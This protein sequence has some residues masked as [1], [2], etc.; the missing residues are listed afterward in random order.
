MQRI[1]SGIQATGIPHIG[2]YI[3]AIK[4]WLQAQD[5]GTDS[6]Y[7][8]ADLHA[9]TT[10]FNPLTLQQNRLGALAGLLACGLDPN[11]VTL[12]LQSDISAHTELCW[13]LSSITRMGELNRMTQFKEKSDSYKGEAALAL[14]S[15]PTLQAAD[16]LLY[17]ATHVPVGHDQKQH[18]ELT[19]DIAQRFNSQFG[20]LFPLPE[21]VIPNVGAR[22]MDLQNPERKMSKSGNV[23]GLGVIFLNDSNDDIV[24][25]VKRSVTDTQAVVRYSEDKPGI[26]NLMTLLAACLGKDIEMIEKEYEGKNYGA[27]KNDVAEALIELV[28]PIRSRFEELVQNKQY[29]NQSLRSSIERARAL[30]RDTL[31]EARDKMGLRSFLE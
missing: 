13:L 25:K 12:F 18:I 23:T 8:I 27:F 9:I 6:F 1:L 16:I 7:M 5:A 24:R 10:D 28:S 3:G 20:Q 21:P 2:N 4:H 26:S 17:K 31:L 22:V 30:S 29:L 15:Y 19:R 14:F 11:K